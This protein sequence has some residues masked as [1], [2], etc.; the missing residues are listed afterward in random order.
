[1][2]TATAAAAA[3][4]A[5]AVC[6]LLKQENTAR[7]SLLTLGIEPPD[8]ATLHTPR[9]STACSAIETIRLMSSAARASGV[10]PTSKEVDMVERQ[11]EAGRLKVDDILPL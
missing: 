7:S 2:G 9:A 11:R 5:A 3:A 1:M 10:D 6:I 4:T 8:T